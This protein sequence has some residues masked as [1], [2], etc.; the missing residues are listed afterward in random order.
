M[1]KTKTYFLFGSGIIDAFDDGGMRA[2]C[3][4]AREECD[5]AVF[6][7]D[8]EK[9]KPS[10]LIEVYDGYLNWMIIDEKQYKK[11]NSL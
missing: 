1:E 4:Y 9:T 11:F 8:A 7:F 3:K 6:C 10:E 2:A 5:W